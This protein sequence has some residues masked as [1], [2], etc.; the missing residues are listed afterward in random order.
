[1]TKTKGDQTRYSNRR[2]TYFQMAF[3][4]VVFKTLKAI[5]IVDGPK[6]LLIKLRI[7]KSI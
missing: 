6:S 2:M 3:L 1:M 5:K 4:H 7:L